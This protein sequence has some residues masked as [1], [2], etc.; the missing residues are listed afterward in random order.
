MKKHSQLL[1]FAISASLGLPVAHAAPSPELC[2][3]LRTFVE[4][5][6][7]DESRAFALRTSWGRNFKD[8]PEPAL[9]AKRCEH[10]GYEPARK[11]CDYLMAHSSTEFAGANVK[12]AITCLSRKT[13][14]AP[15]MELN[16]ESFSF[17][18]GNDNRGALI[19]VTL[20][21]DEKMGGMTFELVAD[22]Y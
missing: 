4:S 20:Q 2:K 3:A 17:S 13:R 12:D 10:G 5:V 16:N 9:R 15:M 7:P 19:D 8:A 21:P 18:Y 6:Q 22:G 14:F 11:L 1:A